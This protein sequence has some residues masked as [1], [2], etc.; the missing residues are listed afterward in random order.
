[1]MEAGWA[2]TRGEE[3]FPQGPQAGRDGGEK[4]DGTCSTAESLAGELPWLKRVY[5]ES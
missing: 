4:T 2:R 3:A 5:H 1:M